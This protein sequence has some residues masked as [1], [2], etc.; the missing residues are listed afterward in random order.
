MKRTLKYYKTQLKNYINKQIKEGNFY[1][2]IIEKT[3]DNLGY[4]D[5]TLHIDGEA[6]KIGVNDDY[7]CDLTNVVDLKYDVLDEETTT[8]IIN[9]T[10]ELLNK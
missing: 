1:I 2:D 5:I 4:V 3:K 7:V 9:K 10:K 6:F 8:I